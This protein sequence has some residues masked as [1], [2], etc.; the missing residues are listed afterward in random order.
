MNYATMLHYSR[1]MR[2]D[3]MFWVL[4]QDKIGVRL[5]A[6]ILIPRCLDLDR[7]KGQCNVSSQRYRSSHRLSCDY[8]PIDA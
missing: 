5:G 4:R 2:L 1:I 3:L 6:A 7:G 8:R